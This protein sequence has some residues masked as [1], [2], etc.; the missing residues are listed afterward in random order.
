MFMVRIFLK[1][2]SSL[3]T[4]KVRARKINSVYSTVQC[5]GISAGPFSVIQQTVIPVH[6]LRCLQGIRQPEKVVLLRQFAG[7]GSPEVVQLAGQLR[8]DAQLASLFKQPLEVRCDIA[9][10]TSLLQRSRQPSGEKE[11]FLCRREN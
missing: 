10:K 9:R 5:Y 11:I 4:I 8:A 6:I 3:L 2:F 1:R 7:A